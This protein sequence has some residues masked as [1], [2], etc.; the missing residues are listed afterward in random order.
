MPWLQL[1]FET[2]PDDAEHLSDLLSEAGASAVTFLDSADQ[3]L[4]EPPVG[5]TPLW[6]RTRVMGL[7]DAATDINHVVEQ[8]SVEL[9]PNPLPDWRVSPLEDKDW[10]REW[11]DN[12][13]PMS[14]GERLWII[15]SW[16]EPPQPEATN[17]LLDPGLA[18]GTG[19]HPTTALCLQWL[20]QHSSQ[21][22]FDYDEVIDYG[23]GSGILAVAAALLGAKHVW[24]V[25]NDPQALIAT[26]DNATKNKVAESIEAVLPEALP[27]I[28][29]PLLLA[30]IL[31][32][33]LMDFA[34]RFAGHVTPGGHI[35]LSGILA[36]QAEQVA[37]SYLP[38]FEMEAPTLQ[39]GWVR[40]TG[41]RHP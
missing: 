10:E 7:F 27:D 23:C 31:A 38:W 21:H 5:E 24:A 3:P 16:T 14:F 32:Q 6:S 2:T 36:E 35:V 29:T 39:D 4:Y 28:K 15:P 26:R 25:D 30:N 41:I 40:L 22:T 19:T 13:K 17:I 18:F 11:M 37:S 33:P 34:E 8:V 12:F 1:T 20:D 9:A